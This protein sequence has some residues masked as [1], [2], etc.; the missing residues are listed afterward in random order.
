MTH[1]ATE[2]N[3]NISLCQSE[4]ES[5][6][7]RKSD[8][9]DMDRDRDFVVTLYLWLP[10]MFPSAFMQITDIF[11]TK[12]SC[13]CCSCVLCCAVLC[14]V[15]VCCVAVGEVRALIPRR[16]RTWDCGSCATQMGETDC[17]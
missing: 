1:T 11:D 17:N 8:Q 2:H 10:R 14:C 9:R 3:A 4:T 13:L 6:T 15:G 16:R 5:W 7:L 12:I